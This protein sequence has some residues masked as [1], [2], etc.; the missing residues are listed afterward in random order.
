MGRSCHVALL[1]SLL[2]VSV[3][4]SQTRAKYE[5]PDGSCY[6]GAFIIPDHNIHG[7]IPEF[8]AATGKKHTGYLTYAGVASP[9]PQAFVDTC[10]AYGAFVQL[11]FEPDGV[12]R[13]LDDTLRLRDW[14]RAAAR[15]GVPIFLRFASEMNLAGDI[16]WAGNPTLYRTK[17][18]LMHR[19]MKEEAPNV[20][21]VWA[22]GWWPDILND[23]TRMI[24]AYYP[25]DEYV[26]WVGVDLYMWGPW[27]DQYQEEGGLSPVDKLNAVYS[28]RINKPMILCEWAAAIREF[29]Q[30]TSVT[31]NTSAY[32]I[33]NIQTLYSDSTLRSWFPRLKGIFWFDYD[34]HAIN[35]SD[36][37]LTEDPGVLAAYRVS[38]SSP[39]FAPDVYYNVPRVDVPY[40]V[41]QRRDSLPVTVRCAETVVE[42]SLIARGQVVQTLTSPPWVFRWDV[43]GLPDADYFVEV[44]SRTEEGFAGRAFGT[45]TVDNDSDYVN[46][47]VDNSDPGF[48]PADSLGYISTSQPDRYGSDYYVVR[49]GSPGFVRWTWTPSLSRR[50]NVYAMWSAHENRSDSVRYVVRSGS[51]DSLLAVV[52]QK[53]DGGIWNLLGSIPVQAGR[54]ASIDLYPSTRG[55]VIADAVK[56]YHFSTTRVTEGRPIASDVILEQNYPNPFNPTTEIRFYLPC[57]TSVRMR[58]VDVLGR[59]REIAMP[60]TLPQG[61][62]TI[63]VNASGWASGTYFCQ[64]VTPARIVTRKMVLTR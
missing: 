23:S 24:M 43:S 16:P 31:T 53:S 55:Y 38:I 21:M 35:G 45:V 3:V 42:A 62:H 64:L 41:L 7:R 26:D 17:W 15:T 60:G 10:D 56:F 11:G 6:I 47:I 32:A 27:W 59:E 2:S 19:I 61:W 20:A 5:P 22:P 44:R 49:P 9:F 63:P 8:E 58:I 57:A 14:A 39:F 18:R 46:A 1:A 12:F 13:D 30:D 40:R 29:R 51:G 34:T 25:G 36:F 50:V 48:S 54:P 28:K 37:L 4:F 33:R 52:D